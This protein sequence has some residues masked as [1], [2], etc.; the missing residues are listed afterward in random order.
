MLAYV[1]TQVDANNDTHDDVADIDRVAAAPAIPLEGQA[2]AVPPAV[3]PSLPPGAI[4]DESPPKRAKVDEASAATKTFRPMYYKAGL[5]S[6]LHANISKSNATLWLPPYTT[7]YSHARQ[8]SWYQ[9][10][11]RHQDTDSRL[12]W[13]EGR[14]PEKTIDGDCGLA[15][16]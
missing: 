13:Y 12:R 6:L 11:F 9:G 16:W 2:G 7:C 10:E 15:N 1:C 4:A 3:L 5:C 8:Q 14:P